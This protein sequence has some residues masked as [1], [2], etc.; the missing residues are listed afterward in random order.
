[1]K[2]E[3]TIFFLMG[4]LLF[5]FMFFPAFVR[6][7]GISIQ[8]IVPNADVHLKPA[9]D[10]LKIGSVPLG[11]IL[12]AEKQI[13]D[14]F[15][16]KLPP[17]ENGISVTGFINIQSVEVLS[18]DIVQEEPEVPPEP[19]PPVRKTTPPPPPPTRETLPP[20]PRRSYTPPPPLPE[21]SYSR[22]G[23]T[24]GLRI[25]GGGTYLFK[26]DVNEA[27]EA[28]S[29]FWEAL[30]GTT[31]YGHFKGVQMG[32][33]ASAE[34]FFNFTPSFGFGFGCGLI[35]AGKESTIASTWESWWGPPNE[36]EDTYHP[37]F[38]TIPLFFNLYFG[39]PGPSVNIVFHAGAGYYM[40]QFD[41]KYSYI[42]TDDP[43]VYYEETWS[44]KKNAFGFQA[45]LD[46]ELKLARSFA[47]II[48]LEGRFVK[49]SN[50]SGDFSWL[51]VSSWW[52]DSGTAP[53]LTLW[54]CEYDTGVGTF[55]E[56]FFSDT[57]P[58]G[59][60]YQNVREAVINLN[61]I[62]AKVG[63]KISM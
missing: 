23:P 43:D 16:V 11:A 59:P 22:S 21:P 14:W 52:E 33:D 29:Q 57:K 44:A 58:S 45:G 12:T 60:G 9:A 50:L 1:M 48:G 55:P 61:G 39:I 17:D 37:K 38:K 31:V 18:E 56:I 4:I 24:F 7:E 30:P 36:Y 19:A 10:S 3:R 62:S 26:N 46:I 34:L 32:I 6:A 53:N 20:P 8:V 42:D 2:K 54:Y 40:G 13:G 49:F 51:D 27:I 35:S 5:F 25:K 15:M 63:F 47:F 28:V 41:W